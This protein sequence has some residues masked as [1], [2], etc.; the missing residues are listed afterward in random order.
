[1]K[2]DACLPW[3]SVL[4]RVRQRTQADAELAPVLVN[5]TE[6]VLVAATPDDVLGGIA[7]DVFAGSVPESDRP[8]PIDKVNGVR[9]GV[10]YLDKEVRLA[11]GRT[12]IRR[13]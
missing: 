7:G 2:P 11:E 3:S 10:E 13:T 8:L 12:Q 9:Q 4:D 5:V 1:M 6:N